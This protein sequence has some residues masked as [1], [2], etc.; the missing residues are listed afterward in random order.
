M[1]DVFALARPAR[2]FNTEEEW[3]TTEFTEN[4]IV[5]W[6]F[7]R[8]KSGFIHMNQF[9]ILKSDNPISAT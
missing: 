4:K 9:R 2:R 5:H 3:R 7:V 6:S 8:I 1:I